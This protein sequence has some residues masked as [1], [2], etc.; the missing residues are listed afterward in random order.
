MSLFSF[1][2]SKVG[3]TVLAR[4]SAEVSFL[5]HREEGNTYLLDF[6]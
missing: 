2:D 6:A 3:G 1:G 4:F 5:L